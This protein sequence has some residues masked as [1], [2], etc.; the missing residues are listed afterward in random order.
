LSIQA[1]LG[2]TVFTMADGQQALSRIQH[3]Q[4]TLILAD[5]A[6]A[7]AAGDS[8]V[9]RLKEQPQTRAILVA[10]MGDGGPEAFDRARAAGCDACIGKPFRTSDLVSFVR[11]CLADRGA[12][13]SPTAE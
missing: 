13:R 9:R 11:D 10:A 7:D 3:V 4:P 1:E 2:L 12:G 8:L 6:A 5:L